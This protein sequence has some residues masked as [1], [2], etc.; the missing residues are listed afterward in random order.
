NPDSP[1]STSRYLSISD[2]VAAQKTSFYNILY[3][4]DNH[5]STPLRVALSRVGRHYA[6]I[7]DGINDGMSTDPITHSCQQNFALL[8]SDGYWN[9]GSG[10][11]VTTTCS[12]IGNQDNTPTAG[13]PVYVS[14]PTGTLDG[15][16]VQ[17]TV[18][19]PFV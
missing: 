1:V 7:T 3:A 2:F 8:T 15:S 19:T 13:T 4:Q 9:D 12:A 10:S 17:Q 14:R 16:N 18:K 11:G 5:G 6:N